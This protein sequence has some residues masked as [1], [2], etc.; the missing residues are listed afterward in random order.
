MKDDLYIACRKQGHKMCTGVV[1][2]ALFGCATCAHVWTTDGTTVMHNVYNGDVKCGSKR[3]V[4]VTK[5]ELLQLLV[6]V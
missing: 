4:S 6:Y 3:Q 2:D 1:P 5:K